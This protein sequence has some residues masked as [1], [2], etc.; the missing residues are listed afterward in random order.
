MESIS[1]MSIQSRRTHFKM[2]NL[3]PP[4]NTTHSAATA[5]RY[6]SLKMSD[7][8]NC[9][10]Y[11]SEEQLWEKGPNQKRDDNS[12]RCGIGKTYSFTTKTAS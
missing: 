9:R 8:N 12:R 7:A 1:Q 2:E 4:S 11:L 5:R 3:L 6:N 10:Q